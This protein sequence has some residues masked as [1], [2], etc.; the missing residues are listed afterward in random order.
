MS[1]INVKI[2]KNQAFRV[3]ETFIQMTISRKFENVIKIK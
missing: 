3:S 2:I 1:T